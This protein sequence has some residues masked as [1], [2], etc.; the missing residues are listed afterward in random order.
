MIKSKEKVLKYLNFCN[1]DSVLEVLQNSVKMYQKSDPLYLYN[2]PKPINFE[3]DA[4]SYEELYSILDC[5]KIKLESLRSAI[6]FIIFVL[7]IRDD[8]L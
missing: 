4:E 1:L 5:K 7:K 3:P 6:S 2:I 8:K